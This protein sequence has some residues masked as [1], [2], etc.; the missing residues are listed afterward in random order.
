VLDDEVSSRSAA[1][2]LQEREQDADQTLRVD[3]VPSIYRGFVFP[4]YVYSQ[5]LEG[6]GRNRYGPSGIRVF[7]E[8]NDF[9]T[10]FGDE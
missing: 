9:L 10:I 7:R 8:V 3:P 1:G 2:L 5:G 6:P 4:R